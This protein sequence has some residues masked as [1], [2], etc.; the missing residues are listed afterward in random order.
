MDKINY[1]IN[2]SLKDN[3]VSAK[4]K[5]LQVNFNALDNSVNKVSQTINAVSTDISNNITEVNT[6]V[7]NVNATVEKTTNNITNQLNRISFAA[8]VDNVRNISDA[9]KS[10][11]GAEIGVGFEQSMAD[12]SS[13]TGIVGKE[14]DDLGQVARE[15][16]KASGLGAAGAADAFALLASQ[17]QVDKIGMEG[18]KTLQ[19]ETITLAQAG[20]MSMADSATAMAATINQFG[21]EATEANRVINVL[22]AGSKYGAAEINDLAQSFKVTGAVASAAGL[23]VEQTAGAIEVLSKNNLKGAEAG[24]ALRNILV[25]MQ[26][27]LGID[28]GKTGL[29]AALEALKPKLNDVTFLAKTFGA[30]NLAA[31]QFLITN[32]A[33]VNE[34]TT[35]VT[36]TNVA[37]EQAAIRTNT[38]AEQMKRMQA[39]VDDL[40][41][42]LFN[43]TGGMTAY[44]SAVGDT[45]VIVAQMI[46]LF[47][48]LKSVVGLVATANGRA[49]IATTAKAVA[50]KAATAVTWTMTAA[51]AALNAVM[52]ANPVALIVLAI[53]ALVAGVIAAYKNFDGFRRIVDAAWQGIK[54]LASAI[55]NGL[56]KAFEKVSAV[57]TPLWGKLKALLGIQDETVQS[58]EKVTAATE[59]LGKVNESA[60][61]SVSQ[62]TALLG[63]QGKKLN[64]NLSTLGGIEQKISILKTKQ[65]EAMGEQAIALEKEIRLWEKKKEAMQNAIIIGAATPPELKPLEAP[66]NKGIDLK[67]AKATNPKLDENG[68]LKVADSG[69]LHKISSEI[70]KAQSKILSFNE[71]LFG[72]NSV[73]ANW[74]DNATSGI[75][76][77]TAIF[78]EFSDMMKNE[79]LSS[80]EKVSGG[81]AAMG[82]M[83]GAMGS[84]VDGA[85]G[86]WL[87]WGANILAM[88][89]AA[90]PQLLTLF[91]IQCAVGISEQASLPFPL[92]L[93]AIGA[94]VAGIA[95]AVASIP[96]P[97]AFANGAIVYG[98]T[99]AQVGEYPGAANN[100]EVIAPLSKL[101]QLIEP[102]G[103]GDGVYEFRLRGRDFVAVAAKYDNINNRTR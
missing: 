39:T 26:T 101:R 15:T 75:T 91:G 89:A 3:N 1:I 35:A 16:G 102:A 28:V 54:N 11:A 70:E 92:N 10:L 68:K 90:I 52:S 21:L 22:A 71:S 47:S 19:K 29:P 85:A 37:Q 81:I 34:M 7:N 14:L 36:G 84:L 46:P 61:S 103:T 20:G 44:I 64:T 27:A 76:R 33:A 4:I 32:A 38:T 94:T 95:A 93:I 6:S 41:I 86:S 49:A 45:A 87:T 66:T 18:L 17:I 2:I 100:P 65:K 97:P 96:K 31:A 58:T 50:E 23:S 25:K 60:G 42:G 56:V 77:I 9:F 88:V 55:W 78:K 74:A 79:T 24:T 51:Q 67:K 62:L 82:A 48:A 98:N 73:I 72:E 63:D 80:V 13:I 5:N 83:M 99:I 43:V 40:K 30:E 53:A 57:L 59:E 8:V 69:P 12:L